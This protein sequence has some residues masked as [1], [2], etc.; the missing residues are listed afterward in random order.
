MK[1]WQKLALV[2]VAALLLTGIISGGTVI[3]RS[4]LYNQEKT[5]ENYEQQL[6]AT[7][8][9]LAK[10]ME[11]SSIESYRESTRKSYLNFLLRRYDASEYILIENDQV[12]SNETSFELSDP[13]DERWK[14]E[15]A[16]SVIQRT[17]NKYILLAGKKIPVSGN[18]AYHLVLIKDIS[19]LYRDIRTQAFLYLLIYL[20]MTVIAVLLIVAMTGRILRPLK[21]LQKAA[22]DIR[23]GE[24][25]RRADVHTKDEIGV[26]A[27][28]FNS[29]AERL[30]RQVKELSGESERRRQMLGSLTHELKT[31]MTSIIGYSDSLLH[32]NL[33]EEQKE[34]ALKHIY[35]ECKR[36]ERLSGKLMSL[37]GMYDNDSICMEKASVRELFEQAALLEEY[38]LKKKKIKLEYFCDMEDRALDKDLFTSLLV[39]LID[40]AAKASEEG[41]VITLTGTGNVISVADQGCGI[42]ASEIERVTEAFYMVDKARSR[43]DG[44]SGLGLALCSKIAGNH[45]AQL[46]IESEL[47]KGTRVLIIFDGTDK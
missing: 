9:A 33:R 28:S 34:R 43:K 38:N 14:G 47:Y 29:M 7:A 19:S 46:H 25:S 17:E 12:I 15:E 1:L 8:Y 40:N 35:E 22:Q 39:N 32:V 18:S 23:E 3:Y 30:E 2:T 5:L 45:G 11:S 24:L 4:T 10:E 37:M 26:M 36:L 21:E 41:A 31:P 20:G 44:G 42:P 6:K 13:G 16:F 27:E